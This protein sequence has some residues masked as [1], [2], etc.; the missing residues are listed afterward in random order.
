[1]GPS[2]PGVVVHYILSRRG[3]RQIDSKSLVRRGTIRTL[4]RTQCNE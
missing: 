1:M 3:V 2:V 4:E